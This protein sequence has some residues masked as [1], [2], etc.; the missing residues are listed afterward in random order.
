MIIQAHH[1]ILDHLGLL[2]LHMIQVHL[3]LREAG[4]AADSTAVD[5]LETGK[6]IKKD[7]SQR[8]SF[9]LYQNLAT[10]KECAK[11]V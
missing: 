6:H 4:A 10:L 11:N 3:G 9:I 2:A 8:V 1:T 5:H 7:T